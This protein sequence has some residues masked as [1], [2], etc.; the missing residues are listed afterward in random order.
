MKMLLSTDFSLVIFRLDRGIQFLI[1]DPRS[2]REMTEKCQRQSACIIQK[3]GLILATI[4]RMPEELF[5]EAVFGGNTVKPKE[6]VRHAKTAE[7]MQFIG[8]M[9]AGLVHEIRNPITGIKGA[10]EVFHRELDLSN[11]DRAV[12]EEMLFQVKKLDVITRSFLEYVRPLAPRFVP[13]NVNEVIR[14][15]LAL[16]TRH[17]LHK[18]IRKVL[19]IEELGEPAPSINADPLQLQQVFLNLTLNALDAMAEGR[20]LRFK[21]ARDRD[22]VIVEVADVGNVVDKETTDKIFPPFFTTGIRGMGVGLSVS[23]RL[24]EQHGG[25]LAVERIE[26]GTV[27]TARFPLLNGTAHDQISVAG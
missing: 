14:D 1:L 9:A 7:Q 25:Q 24:I 15:S 12:F 10:L 22:T 2:S 16:V 6:A 27:F 11:E 17:N 4:P 19:I 3:N 26:R 13:S 8:E 23:K 18:N 5:P 20:T 21:T